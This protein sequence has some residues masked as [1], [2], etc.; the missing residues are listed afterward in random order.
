MEDRL[1]DIVSKVFG[2][3]KN[4]IT[5]E[6]GFQEDLGADSLD[7]VELAEE[8]ETEFDITVEDD[9]MAK[10]A[11]FGDLVNLIQQSQENDHVEG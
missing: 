11:T 2:A 1:R 4:S 3:D 8:L 7:Y 6:T 10:I 5:P 9:D